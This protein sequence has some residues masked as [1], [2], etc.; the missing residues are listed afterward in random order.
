MG[1]QWRPPKLASGQLPATAPR[2]FEFDGVDD[3]PD[4]V[5]SKAAA[6]AD[7]VGYQTRNYEALPDD[8]ICAVVAKDGS[9]A[10]LAEL[11]T[12]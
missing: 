1:Q 3:S 8:A 5:V 9:R 10:V 12:R 11:L 2:T 6:I 4:F 7:Y